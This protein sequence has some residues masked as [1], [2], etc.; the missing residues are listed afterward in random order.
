METPVDP[1]LP[2][3]LVL[4]ASERSGFDGLQPAANQAGTNT[5]S[6]DVAAADGVR[7]DLTLLGLDRLL[8]LPLDA[9]GVFSSPALFSEDSFPSFHDDDLPAPSF[10]DDDLPAPSIHG[11][12]LPADLT[13]VDLGRLLGLHLSS[14]N[15]PT[16]GEVIQS[17]FRQVETSEPEPQDPNDTN[18]EDESPVPEEDS[19]DPSF[20]AAG[21]LSFIDPQS[22]TEQAET[23]NANA[24][25]GG[26]FDAEFIGLSFPLHDGEFDNDG[27]FGDLGGTGTPPL[28]ESGTESGSGGGMNVINGTAGDDVLNGTA[29]T[30]FLHGLAGNDILDG[31]AGSDRLDG[32]LGDDILVWDAADSSIDG[33]GGT[34]TLRVDGG[35]DADFT[36]F[37]GT[38]SDLEVVDL[39][40]DP[41]ANDLT[42]TAQNVLDMTDNGNTLT[43]TGAVGDRLFASN[44]WT[45]GGIDSNGNQIYTQ[46]VGPQTATLVVDPVITV[47]ANILL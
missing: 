45:D 22:F 21:V 25:S 47:N 8:E 2:G 3:G 26:Q 32:G 10:H 19:S 27:V 20:D 6:L 23:N 17:A 1:S 4:V 13:T 39:L 35:S 5:A 31:G 44:G 43:I 34:D 38:M 9:S 18:S 36:M 41:S 33:K 30:D 37:G 46:T 16:V 24:A 11:Y 12:D 42:L 28:E 29:G 15:L 7:A 40:S 14:V